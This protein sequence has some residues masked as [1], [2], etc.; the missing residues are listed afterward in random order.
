GGMRTGRPFHFLALPT[1][2]PMLP[3]FGRE[4]TFSTALPYQLAPWPPQHL[5]PGE[6]GQL[7]QMAIVDGYVVLLVERQ[8][9]RRNSFHHFTVTPLRL[10]QPLE[11]KLSLAPLYPQIQRSSCGQH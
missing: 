10:L 9:Q 5:V 11:Q 2:D 1:D 4:S 7:F 3:R 8:D 6:P